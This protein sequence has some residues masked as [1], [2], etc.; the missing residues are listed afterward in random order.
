MN[1]ATLDAA[2]L[3]GMMVEHNPLQP[4][5]KSNFQHLAQHFPIDSQLFGVQAQRAV[6]FHERQHHQHGRD[7]LADDGGQGHACHVH[8][9]Y[10]DKE[11]IEQYVDDACDGQIDHRPLSVA[12]GP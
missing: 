11:Q 9:Q 8:L 6:L 7:I 10:N 4:R 3:P 12:L 2:A 1:P 5:R